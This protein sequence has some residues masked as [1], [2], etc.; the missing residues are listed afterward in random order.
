M[1]ARASEGIQG[2]PTSRGML[3]TASRSKLDMK[4]SFWVGGRGFGGFVR[5]DDSLE[6][7]K[8]EKT[9][10]A[11]PVHSVLTTQPRVKAGSR[12]QPFWKA[13]A[14]EHF[15]PCQKS[16][17]TSFRK[18]ILSIKLICSSIQPPP[19]LIDTKPYKIAIAIRCKRDGQ[20][21]GRGFVHVSTAIN[22]V[23]HRFSTSVW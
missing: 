18:T 6:T 5:C 12:D 23:H 20:L 22:L 7:P 10:A 14:N 3:R 16:R 11:S 15:I 4:V 13:K 1:E 21:F 8:A 9:D 19:R 17:T 2:G